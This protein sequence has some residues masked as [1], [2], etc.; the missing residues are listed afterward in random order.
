MVKLSQA[1]T[2]SR[3]HRFSAARKRA[4]ASWRYRSADHFPFAFRANGEKNL[5][6]RANRG[7]PAGRLHRIIPAVGGSVIGFRSLGTNDREV[8]NS[9]CF[10]RAGHLP[11]TC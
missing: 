11:R 3:E 10:D 1:D 9:V 5:L 8:F 6:R 4:R 2:M 7:A